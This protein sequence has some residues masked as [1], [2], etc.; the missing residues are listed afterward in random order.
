MRTD[1]LEWLIHFVHRRNPEDDP[2]NRDRL[3][4]DL[5]FHLGGLDLYANLAL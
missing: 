1:L 5:F 4:R 2:R 3:N